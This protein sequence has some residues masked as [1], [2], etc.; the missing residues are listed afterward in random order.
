MKQMDNTRCVLLA[1]KIVL[2]LI[3][4]LG[5]LKTVAHAEAAGDTV[6]DHAQHIARVMLAKDYQD[7]WALIDDQCS[8]RSFTERAFSLRTRSLERHWEEGVLTVTP[9]EQFAQ[10]RSQRGDQTIYRY[11]IQP[12]HHAFFAI[13]KGDMAGNVIVLNPLVKSK[14]QWRGLDGTCINSE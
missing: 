8:P 13:T 10:D 2:L 5:G 6:D 4:S 12:T 3:V 7:Y 1:G 11:T 9:Y 14:G